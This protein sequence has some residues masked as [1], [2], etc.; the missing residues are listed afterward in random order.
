M[1]N[2]ETRVSRANEA[3]LEGILALQAANQAARGGSLAASL[4]RSR[5]AAMMREMPIIV[6]RRGARVTGFLMTTTREMNADL[7]IVQAMFGA[8]HGS[9]D[10]YVYGPICVGEEERGKGLAQMMFADLRRLEPGREGVLFIRKD[11]EPSLR[12]HL[13]MGMKEVAG[14]VFNGFEYA[15][16]SYIG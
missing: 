7:P 13:K 1:T 10:A 6:A 9:S 16:F 5:V 3:D 2:D 11:N 8:Y 14:F 12:A 15:V 4:P